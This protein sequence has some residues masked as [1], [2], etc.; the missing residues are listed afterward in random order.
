MISDKKNY[1]ASKQDFEK[2]MTSYKIFIRLMVLLSYG[3]L[4]PIHTNN[5]IN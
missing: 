5:K 3:C 1:I 2:C 4:I